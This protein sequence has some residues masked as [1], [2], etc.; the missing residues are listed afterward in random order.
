MMFSD[1]GF[2]CM[3]ARDFTNQIVKFTKRAF[4]FA[5]IRCKDRNLNIDYIFAKKSLISSI[6][7]IEKS[8]RLESLFIANIVILDSLAVLDIQML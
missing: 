4:W 1:W 2:V 8:S 6:I 5:F 3:A 7:A